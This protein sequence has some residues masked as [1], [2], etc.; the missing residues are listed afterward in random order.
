VD[1]ELDER[2]E[3]YLDG[4]LSE[5]ETCLFE[6]DMANPDVARAVSQALMIRSVMRSPVTVPEGLADRVA[7][8]L[9]GFRAFASA[10]EVTDTSTWRS[11]LDSM[12]WA[13][14]GSSM[15]LSGASGTGSG[16]SAMAVGLK[17]VRYG[18]GPISLL[19]SRTKPEGKRPWKWKLLR[20][21]AGW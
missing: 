7:G 5:D 20:R 8:I 18:L 6:R 15:A 16:Y 3:G 10:P 14:S 19:T 11:V 21:A 12:G 4:A 1:R 9:T 13:F 2:V 17:A